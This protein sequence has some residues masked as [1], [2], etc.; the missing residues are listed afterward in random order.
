M[1]RPS[2]HTWSLGLC[3]A[4][5]F[6][7]GLVSLIWLEGSNKAAITATA[8]SDKATTPL[9]DKTLANNFF[10]LEYPGTYHV[11][12]QT[13]Q[14]PDLVNYLLSADTTYDKHLSLALVRG[15][16]STSSAYLYRKVRTDIYSSQTLTVA[17]EAA[18]LW[19]KTDHTEVTVIIPHNNMVLTISVSVQN[20]NATNGLPNEMTNLLATLRWQ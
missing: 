14:L 18:S 7:F 5:V 17:G 11:Q 6:I 9:A 16:I 13:P 15:N 12:S 19:T 10:S 8:S 3:L 1:I 20:S 2:R 4:V